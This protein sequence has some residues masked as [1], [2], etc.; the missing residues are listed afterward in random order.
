MTYEAGRFGHRLAQV[1]PVEDGDKVER[2]KPR[3]EIISH[4]IFSRLMQKR[5]TLL[6]NHTEISFFEYLKDGWH[7]IYAGWT[8][9]FVGHTYILEVARNAPFIIRKL[10]DKGKGKRTFDRVEDEDE[11]VEKLAEL[12][13]R[14]LSRRPYRFEGRK[15]PFRATPADVPIESSVP[16]E[17]SNVMAYYRPILSNITGIDSFAF[18]A[19]RDCIVAGVVLFQFTTA[20]KHDIKSTFIDKLWTVLSPAIREKPWKLVFVIPKG[21]HANPFPTSMPFKSALVQIEQCV[22]E[23]NAHE[24]W[25]AGRKFEAEGLAG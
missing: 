5:S 23:V 7:G 21:K 15:P 22:L 3:M 2:S 10:K 20:H 25:N 4:Y 8:W 13:L 11:D 1:N 14:H 18:E 9:E 19:D 16:N 6:I 17:P 24:L 12:D